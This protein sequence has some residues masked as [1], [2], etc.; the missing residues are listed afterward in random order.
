MDRLGGHRLQLVGG[1]LHG[2]L[3]GE[4]SEGAVALSG[5]GHREPLG[6][7]PIEGVPGLVG[8]PLLVDLLIHSGENSKEV[9]ASG[10]GLGGRAEGVHHVNGVGRL[11]LPGSGLE[12]VGEV[13]EGADGAEVDHIS[14]EFVGDHVLDVGGDLVDGT[15]SD[16]AEG[17]LT[18]DLLSEPDAPGAVDAPGH[19]CL[20]QRSN[21]LVLHGTLVLVVPTLVEAVDL[22]DI[23]QVAL[24]ALIADGAVKRV[25]G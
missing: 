24:A 2:L 16:L 5:H 1:E 9:G 10:V 19:G 15:S 17:E 4:L 21:V 23:L 3:P 12:R 13:V 20:D 14:G 22:G 8:D 25:V 18:G 6:L 7:E 11:E